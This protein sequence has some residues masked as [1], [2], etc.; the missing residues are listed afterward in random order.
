M[1]K[2]LI[3]YGIPNCA[4]VKKARLWLE[5]QQLPVQFHDFKKQGVPEQELDR[6]IK[7]LGWQKLVNRAGT[8]WRKLPPQEQARIVDAPSARALMLSQP[9]IIKRPVVNWGLRGVTVGFDAQ[10]WSARTAGAGG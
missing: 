4:T 3:L 6:W 10:D 9:S 8:T 5:E 7:Q 1:S 2:A